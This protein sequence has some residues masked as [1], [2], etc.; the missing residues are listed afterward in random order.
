MSRLQS[1]EKVVLQVLEEVP[2]AREDDYVLMYYVCLRLNKID[3]LDTT[4]F[5][6]LLHHKQ[7]DMPNWESV[8]RARR[9]VQEKRPDLVS[10]QKAKKRHEEEKVYR[11]YART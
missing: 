2:L 11:E 10:P 3:L 8:T 9:K 7:Y 5:D 6:A 4:F 1:V